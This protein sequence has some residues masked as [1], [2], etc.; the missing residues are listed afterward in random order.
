[1]LDVPYGLE[2][3]LRWYLEHAGV[4]TSDGMRMKAGWL[5]IAVVAGA[6]AQDRSIDRVVPALAAGKTC[7]SSIQLQNLGEQPVTV[8][9][10]A[11]GENGTLVALKGHPS[12]AVELAPRRQ[13][14]YRLELQEETTEAWVRVR[15]KPAAGANSA[16]VAVSGT[17]ECVAGN[18]LHAAPRGVAFPMQNPWFDGDVAELKGEVLAV[19]NTAA[20]AATAQLCYSSAAFYSVP[21]GRKGG[22]LT[23]VCTQSFAVQLPPFSAR[24]FPVAREGN[25]HFSLHTRGAAVV[26]Q[27]LKPQGDGVRVYAVDSTIHFGAEVVDK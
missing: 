14:T 4:D 15:E 16:V 17:T 18:E 27:M 5:I 10:E 20:Q 22:E 12:I 1:M 23:P 25:S 9:V 26:L 11:Y 13:E 6:A 21:D 24:Q 7:T 8:R 2:G 19:V 3:K